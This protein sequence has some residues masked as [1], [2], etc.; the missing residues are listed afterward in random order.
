MRFQLSLTL[1][2]VVT[3]VELQM[4]LLQHSIAVL[5]NWNKKEQVE[6]AEELKKSLDKR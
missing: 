3:A 4:C 2:I 1:V 5:Q 6:E